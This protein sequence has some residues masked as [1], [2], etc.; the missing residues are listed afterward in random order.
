MH[1]FTPYNGD[2]FIGRDNQNIS[3]GN[4]FLLYPP[5]KKVAK[6]EGIS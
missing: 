5:K 2:R 1:S 4:I 3:P 6:K